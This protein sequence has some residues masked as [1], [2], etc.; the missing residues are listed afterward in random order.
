MS[1]RNNHMPPTGELAHNAGTLPDQNGTGDLSYLQA[2]AQ[3]TEPH[4]PGLIKLWMHF[5]NL[6]HL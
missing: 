6:I 1:K 5:I 3:S 2:A 4:Q